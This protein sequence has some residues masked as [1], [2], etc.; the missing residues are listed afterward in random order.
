[1]H[2]KNKISFEF[3]VDNIKLFSSENRQYNKQLIETIL[4]CELEDSFH[5]LYSQKDSIMPFYD[6]T[7]ISIFQKHEDRFFIKTIEFMR[8]VVN[9]SRIIY[10]DSKQ[11]NNIS[12]YFLMK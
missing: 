8:N 5:I 12:L 10:F 6:H 3:N 7:N 1:M 4:G 9:Y 2:M 11:I